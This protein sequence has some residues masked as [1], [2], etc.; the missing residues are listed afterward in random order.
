MSVGVAPARVI[1][2]AWAV[3]LAV[4]CGDEICL[5]WD[6]ARGPC[7]DRIDLGKVIA[8]SGGDVESIDSPGTFEDGLCCY[9]ATKRDL[10]DPF[11]VRDD[12]FQTPEPDDGGGL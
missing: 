3:V 10:N 2:T 5:E 7:P 9:E 6:D 8:C 1:W 11:I 12:C 4:G